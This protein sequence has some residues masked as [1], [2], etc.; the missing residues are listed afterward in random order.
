MEHNEITSVPHLR[1]LGARVRQDEKAPDANEKSETQST[2]P[3]Q[4]N[5][6]QSTGQG[7]G[8]QSDEG[9]AGIALADEVEEILNRKLPGD[10]DA[11]E[12]KEKPELRLR[13]STLTEDPMLLGECMLWLV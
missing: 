1:L 13:S 8:S 6:D 5:E 12:Q 9:K 10:D 7:S 2:K 3:E 4:K 11:D